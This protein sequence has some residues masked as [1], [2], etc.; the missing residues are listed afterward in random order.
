MFTEHLEAA[1]SEKGSLRDEIPQA[2]VR[3]AALSCPEREVS[4]ARIGEEP[5][6][7]ITIPEKQLARRR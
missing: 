4:P 7:T 2:G 3:A 1:R 5:K 6:A